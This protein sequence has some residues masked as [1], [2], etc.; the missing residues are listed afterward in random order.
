MPK[1]EFKKTNKSKKETKPIESTKISEPVSTFNLSEFAKEN[2]QISDT[3]AK[4]GRPRKNK[5]YST[6]R[7][8][9]Y[10]VNRINSLQNTLEFDTQDDLINFLIDRAE[11]TLENEQRIMFDMYMKTYEARDKKTK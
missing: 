5:V 9:K 2:Q 1:Y 6:I 8:Q 4:M 7:I 10:N 3:K 11:N